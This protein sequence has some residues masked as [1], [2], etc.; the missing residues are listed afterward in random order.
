MTKSNDELPSMMDGQTGTDEISKIFADKYETLYNTVSYNK[1][2]MDKLKEVIDSNIAKECP[3][4]LVQPNNRHS[5]TVKELKEAIDML[6]LGKKEENGLYSNHFKYGSERLFILLTLLFNS[7][8]SH[9]ISPGELLVGTIIPLNTIK[10][11][12]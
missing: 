8:L 12:D 1:Q 9:G 3:N 2:D 5:I 6:K 11:I 10:T 4:G 7:I